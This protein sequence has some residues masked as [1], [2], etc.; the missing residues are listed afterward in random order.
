MN[1]EII[2][3]SIEGNYYTAFKIIQY[4]F[5]CTN[6]FLILIFY[7]INNYKFISIFKL[8]V[9]FVIDIIIRC[10]EIFSYSIQDNIYKE[11]AISIMELTQFLLIIS[12]INKG[13]I[14]SDNYVNKNTIKLFEYVLLALFFLIISA[15]IEKFYFNENH[16][17]H[18]CKCLF[19][20]LSL[21]LF[22]KYIMKKFKEFLGSI[23]SK[24]K[25]NIC[26]FI[27][28]VSI[29]KIA[30]YLYYMKFFLKFIH[31]YLT[32]I[33]KIYINYLKMAIISINEAAKYSICIFFGGLSYIYETNLD[34]NNKGNDVYSVTVNQDMD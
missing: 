33:N 23:V 1:K 21:F 27:V 15:P 10:L 22:N 6:I 34:F 19:S 26:L 5:S 32:Y 13:F 31:A 12:Y 3:Q 16:I 11:I 20:F 14:N 28:L 30:Y 18:I 9:I 17:F 8:F 24:M 25:L 2:E 29:P 4:F 7:F